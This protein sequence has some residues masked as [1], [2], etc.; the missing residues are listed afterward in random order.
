MTAEYLDSYQSLVRKLW[1][2]PIQVAG[3]IPVSATLLIGC[4]LLIAVIHKYKTIGS[5]TADDFRPTAVEKP[6]RA[7][8]I[9]PPSTFR[10]PQAQPY[11]E[12][13][14]SNT[15]PLP[16]RPF[17][18]GTYNIT[19]G[20]RRMKWDDWIELDNQYPIFHKRKQERIVQRGS[21]LSRTS[22]EA[23][24]AAIELLEEL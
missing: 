12:W 11:P 5:S 10:R 1:A 6:I 21:L 4:I 22:P 3:G 17:R 8:G 15:K 23:W 19:M 18:Y 9:W 24:D 13:T 20:I 16:Y 2:D 7:P 14:I